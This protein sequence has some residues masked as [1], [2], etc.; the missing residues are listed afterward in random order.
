MYIEIIASS[1]N[2]K[3]MV[4]RLGVLNN[5]SFATVHSTMAMTDAMMRS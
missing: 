5:L 4:R 3:E 2:V 1:D